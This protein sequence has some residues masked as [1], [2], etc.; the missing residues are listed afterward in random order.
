MFDNFDNDF[1]EIP[2]TD[3]EIKSHKKTFSNLCF[4][5]LAYWLII[6]VVAI[7]VSFILGNY[8]PNVLQNYNVNLFISLTIQYA[9]AFPIFYLMLKKIPETVQIEKRKL[10]FRE[11]AKYTLI[12]CF[13]MYVGNTISSVLIDAVQNLLGKA[14]ENQVSTLLDNTNVIISVTLA[15]I[16]GPIFEEIMFRKLLVK[17]LMPYGDLVAIIFPS[18]LFALFH[19]NLYQMF[20][21][22]LIG[23][24]LSYVYIKSGKI[25]YTMIL[26][27]FINLFFGVIPSIVIGSF[28]YQAFVELFNSEN[29]E[30]I[31]DFVMANLGALLFIAIYDLVYY[32]LAIGG[33]V[34]FGINIRKVILNKGTVKFPKGTAA[35]I[36]FFNIGTI[37]LIATLVL[38]TAINTFS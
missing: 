4:S 18:L 21:A 19:Q 24:S 6:E 37:L 11:F 29:V 14:P 13:A 32:G 3:A 5:L 23:A 1:N 16:V 10:K 28:D 31:T 12:V 8:A 20:Y 27:V 30:A 34:I 33:A 36:I 9:I 26:H 15:G 2:M 38:M 35:D 25:I 7:I 22:F 17:K